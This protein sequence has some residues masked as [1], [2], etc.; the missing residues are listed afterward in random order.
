MAAQA[1]PS[2]PAAPDP[3][4][5]PVVTSS[6][7]RP[8]C[9]LL[10]LHRT[11]IGDK[12]VVAVTGIVFLLFQIAHM[13]GNLKIF[14]GRADSN[15]HAARLRNAGTPAPPHRTL[16][17]AI[18][19]VTIKAFLAFGLLLL[20][21]GTALQVAELDEPWAEGGRTRIRPGLSGRLTTGTSR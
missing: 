12:A 8:G 13:R 9:R 15:S 2:P 1:V 10:R 7:P 14:L 18:A 4:R 6:Q 16:R 19:P 11:T 20:N 3:G 17:T 5:R 21:N